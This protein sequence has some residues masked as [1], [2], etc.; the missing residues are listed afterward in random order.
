ML[1]D[2]Q[3]HDPAIF[4]D[5]DSSDQRTKWDLMLELEL[6]YMQAVG[7]DR[8]LLH[9][10][11]LPWG[12]YAVSRRPDRFGLVAMVGLTQSGGID[13]LTPAIDR[14]I[15]Q[16]RATAGLV[17]VRIARSGGED[18]LERF[19][20]TIAA[21]AHEGL[22]L[23]VL[24]PGDLI[25]PATI[26]GWHPDLTI[27]IDHIGL[28][29]PPFAT[30][31][32]PL[33][34]SLPSLL[35]L[36]AHRNI[37]VKLS[38]APSMSGRAYPYDDLWPHLHQIVDAFGPQRLMWGSDISRFIGRIGFVIPTMPGTGGDGFVPNHSYAEAL[39]FIR[40]TNEL[41]ADD[42]AWILGRTA[43]A[44]VPWPDAIAQP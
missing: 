8:A 35:A 37:A 39:F 26:A 6:A 38:G 33:F 32:S 30:P 13:P 24:S 44:L 16:K 1:I 5:W 23:F 31:G 17:G 22:P 40:E 25:A 20:P 29:Q 36:A 21:C 12:E 28:P 10:L 2:A 19:R 3:L 14:V 7:V 41:S 43:Q 27:V 34:E 15:A 42:K 18:W 9:P 4:L 11:D